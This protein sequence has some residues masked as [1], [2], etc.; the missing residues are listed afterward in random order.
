MRASDHL[1]AR[2]W[3]AFACCCA[4]ALELAA[5]AGT[6]VPVATGHRQIAVTV[7]DL[8]VISVT[9]IDAA[10]KR[11]LTRR[12]LDSIGAHRIPAIGF[13]NEY[14]LYGLR[15]EASGAP[16]PDEVALLQMW[17]DAGLELG[18][19]TFAHTDL[20]A[21]PLAVFKEDIVRGEALT[22]RLLRQKAMQ[23]R[24]FRHPYLNTGRDLATKREVERFLAERGYRVA[25]VTVDSEDWLFGAA[26]S[27][28]AERGDAKQMRRIG[29]E[30]IRY[31]ERALE[32]GERLSVALFGREIR[33]ILLV[34]ANALNADYFDE[35]ARMMKKRGYAF[36][37]LDQALR[38]E[39]HG[40]SDTYTGEGGIIWLER[41]AVTKGGKKAEDALAGFPKV[42]DFVVKAAG[43]GVISESVKH[44][45]RAPRPLHAP[46]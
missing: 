42:P 28:A 27:K 31:A 45:I 4:L 37:S 35:L 21:S 40:S 12:L 18:N 1:G 2:L 7:D 30:Y 9:P 15:K 20:H 19:H 10:G 44:R 39:A 46:R 38:D 8:P 32:Y 41:W 16:N 26:Y 14:A 17:L 24:Y 23:P 36:V 5:W 13:V 22:R 33:Q 43:V 6:E 3:S 25:P 29:A 11:D 34:H